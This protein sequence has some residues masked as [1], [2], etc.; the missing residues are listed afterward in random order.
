[1]NKAATKKYVIEE[2]EN[3]N[4]YK[5]RE[6]VAELL[7]L[8]SGVNKRLISE[9]KIYPRSQFRYI[10]FYNSLRGGGAI[11][12]GNSFWHSITFT[13]NFFSNDKQTFKAV[14]Y[15]DNLSVWLRLSAHEVGHITHTKRFRS[16]IWYLI[17]FAYQYIKHGHDDAPLEIEAELGRKTFIQFN[18]Y[19]KNNFQINLEYILT[20]Q[21]SDIVKIKLIKK[22]WLEYSLFN[23]AQL[24]A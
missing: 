21:E 5:F 10:P 13:E 8:V 11:T 17:V 14:A 15:G 1:M 24:S 6:P 12:L 3:K 23:S 16:F 19:I 9:T 7:S 2:L 20:S 22:Y 18:N 4:V